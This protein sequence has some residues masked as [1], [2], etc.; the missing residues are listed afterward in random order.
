MTFI[1]IFQPCNM[2]M[3]SKLNYLF[4]QKCQQIENDTPR[5]N[6]SL[7]KIES[8]AAVKISMSTCADSNRT[9]ASM[10]LFIVLRDF[11]LMKCPDTEKPSFQSCVPTLEQHNIIS[12]GL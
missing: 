10:S 7:N 8:I 9:R 6:F 1:N 11:Y 4:T 3:E 2:C 12:A 5:S